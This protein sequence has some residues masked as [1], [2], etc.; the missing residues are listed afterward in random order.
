MAKV[1]GFGPRLK[2]LKEAAHLISIPSPA[3]SATL[4]AE[5]DKLLLLQDADLQATKKEWDAHRREIC[6]ACGNL[7]VPGWSCEVS[8]EKI[9]PDKVDKD[10]TKSP[11]KRLS[12]QGKAMAYSCL[13]CHR[14]TVQSLPPRPPKHLNRNPSQIPEAVPDR[15]TMKARPA[16]QSRVAKS[17]SSNSKQRA[18]ARKGG[19]HAILGKSKTQNSAQQGGLGLDLMDFLK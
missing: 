14:R 13:R 7:M 4:G 8:P 9:V 11:S 15:E 18:K 17:T 10:K 1:D 5:Y 12:R 3:V 2:F 19:L 6:G 16:D